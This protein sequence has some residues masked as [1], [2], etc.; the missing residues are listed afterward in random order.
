MAAR[1]EFTVE[2]KLDARDVFSELRR[3]SGVVSEAEAHIRGKLVGALKGLKGEGSGLGRVLSGEIERAKSSAAGLA[4]QFEESGKKL[5]KLSFLGGAVGA[6]LGGVLLQAV[7]QLKALTEEGVQ[8]LA[9]QESLEARIAAALRRRGEAAEELTAKL[10]QMAEQMKVANAVD[11]DAIRG[12][13]LVFLAYQ[14]IGTEAVPRATQAAIDLA[15]ALRQVGGEQVSLEE[16]AR[17]LGRALNDPAQGMGAL[18]RAGIQL[19]EQTKKTIT[20]LQ[21]QGRIA[22]AQAMLL[23]EIEK[24][25]GGTGQAFA[26]SAQGIQQLFQLT[27]ADLGKALAPLVLEIQKSV[28][29]VFTQILQTIIPL[30]SQI[31]QAVGQILAP[32]AQ[33]IAETLKPVVEALVKALAPVIDIV[34]KLAT[35]IANALQPVL[36]ALGAVLSDVLGMLAEALNEVMADLQPVLEEIG[37]ILR[38]LGEQLGGIILELLQDIKEPLRDILRVVALGLVQALRGVASILRFLSPIIAFVAKLLAKVLAVAVHVAAEALKIFGNV[39]RWVHQRVMEVVDAIA[40]AVRWVLEFFGILSKQADKAKETGTEVKKTA[41]ATQELGAAIQEIPG[42]MPPDP[43]SIEERRKQ[44]EQLRESVRK[45]AKEVIQEQERLRLETLE[46]QFDIRITRFEK[47]QSD[48]GRVLQQLEEQVNETGRKF[49]DGLVDE[50]TYRQQLEQLYTLAQQYFEASRNLQELE[51]TKELELLRERQR[52]Q[53]AEFEEQ[54]AQRLQLLR[55]AL[56][57]RA[58][59]EREYQAEVKKLEELR[60]AFIAQQ[61]LQVEKTQEKLA[62]R[63]EVLEREITDRIVSYNTRAADVILQH[64]ENLAKKQEERLRQL[65]DTYTRIVDIAAEA[66]SGFWQFQE[67][68]AKHFVKTWLDALLQLAENELHIAIFRSLAQEVG[69]KGILGLATAAILAGALKAAFGAMR[70]AIRG[71]REGGWTGSGPT[72]EVAGVV[73]RREFVIPAP[74]AERFRPV[75]EEMRR[76]RLPSIAP[77]SVRVEGRID[78][79]LDEA[80]VLHRLSARN[81]KLRLAR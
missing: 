68:A 27:L 51:S 11:D 17:L 20:T 50:E 57:K 40:S 62:A 12:A 52:V 66:W 47:L 77:T 80:L 32:L 76:G 71:F 30:L 46:L 79:R 70:S 9:K 24:R 39:M 44:I 81:V 55:E 72:T 33:K 4:Q 16:T 21:Q 74:Y 49:A 14:N 5:G 65:R 36:E 6:A 18:V 31:T 67:D 78:V 54:Q 73:H 42:E 56:R 2:L 19:D 28:L 37:A 53:L 25:V 35:A 59:T 26:Q 75:L 60:T 3:V 48:L 43:Q 58:I 23:S 64:T 22:E 61:A 29:P 38:E 41:Q 69:S 15:L 45:L 1:N 7:G 13:Q 8:A 10:S 34:V 63:R